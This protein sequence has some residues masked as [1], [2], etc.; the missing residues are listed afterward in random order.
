MIE[1][2]KGKMRRKIIRALIYGVLIVGVL[3]LVGPFLW[4]VSTSFKSYGEIYRFPPTLIPGSFTFGNYQEVFTILPFGRF[5]FN[6]LIVAGSMLV[7]IVLLSS[8]AGFALA[9]LK[10]RGKTVIFYALLAALMM[11]LLL[12][13]IPNLIMS[14]RLGLFNTFPGIILPY[15]AW[16]LPMPTLL[17]RSFFL[18]LPRSLDDAARIDGASN[19]KIWYKIMLPLSKPMVATVAVFVW[20]FGWD[21]LMWVLTVTSTTEMRTFPVGLALFQSGPYETYWGLIT[22]ASSVGF[23]FMVI[24]Y[25][26][27]HKYFMPAAATTGIKG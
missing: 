26:A 2:L 7:G 24:L 11:P 14:M 21:E 15:I 4:M 22:A 9:R 12:L 5:I 20:L 13:L 16:F 1:K 23:I 27:L 25:M 3:A 10:F 6:T 8:L 19:L 18:S 17:M